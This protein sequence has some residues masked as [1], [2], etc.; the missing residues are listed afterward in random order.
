M[1][2]CKTPQP[3]PRAASCTMRLALY[4]VMSQIAP[5]YRM[6]ST[7]ASGVNQNEKLCDWITE[8]MPLGLD[9]YSTNRQWEFFQTIIRCVA[10]GINAPALSLASHQ[11][12]TYT[13]SEL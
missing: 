10:V 2:W 3:H 11:A 13:Q 5:A 7:G 12:V 8:E 9:I 1:N 6:H 4:E